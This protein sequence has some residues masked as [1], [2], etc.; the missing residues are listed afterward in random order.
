MMPLKKEW[1]SYLPNSGNSSLVF[2]RV[3]A[4]SRLNG[5]APGTSEFNR[6]DARTRRNCDGYLT[7]LNS[8]HL[9]VNRGERNSCL[10][11]QFLFIPE[12]A[13]FTMSPRMLKFTLSTAS[14]RLVLLGA[15][16]DSK[17]FPC[18]EVSGTSPLSMTP[19]FKYLDPLLYICSTSGSACCISS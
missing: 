7:S 10:I 15:G 6:E 5:D 2:L 11:F 3:L 17:I 18:T 16:N 19:A 13:N 12:D 14:M 1:A 9:L 4:P 8:S